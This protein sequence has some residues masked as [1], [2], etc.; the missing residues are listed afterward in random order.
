MLSV[1]LLLSFYFC[2]SLSLSLLLSRFL[3]KNAFSQKPGP[4]PPFSRKQQ[5]EEER[6]RREAEWSETAIHSEANATLYQEKNE[7]EETREA[8]YIPSEASLLRI[9]H[10][11]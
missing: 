2:H 3:P 7:K 11:V 9:H 1:F 6:K 10:S 4:N 5:K 8:E